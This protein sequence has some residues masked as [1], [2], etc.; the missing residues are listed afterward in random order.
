MEKNYADINYRF[1]QTHHFAQRDIEE[2]EARMLRA[3]YPRL[4]HQN[5]RQ[6]SHGTWK[7]FS[8]AQWNATMD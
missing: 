6:R 7:Y 2:D 8:E 4:L 5:G 1:H 3:M